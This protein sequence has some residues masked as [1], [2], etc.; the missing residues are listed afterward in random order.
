MITSWIPRGG[1]LPHDVWAARHR[2]L[3]LVLLAH[4]MV[5]PAF[6]VTQGWSLTAAWGFDL[7]P[8]LLGAAACIPRLG[9][10][11]RSSLCA[12]ALLSCSAV[13]VVAWHGTT[14]AHF[15]YFVMV[16]ALALYQ[17]WWTYLIAI[18]FVVLQHGAFGAANTESVFQHAHH[19]WKWAAIHGA[20]VAALAVTSLVSWRESE[21]VREAT[22]ASEERFKRAFDDAPVAIALVSPRGQIVQANRELRERTGHGQPHGLRLWDLLP[23]RDRV[24][25]SQS[26]PPGPD[27][28]E[29]ERR[30]VRADGSTG[31]FLWR[32]SLIR[33]AAGQP[34]HWVFQGVEITA[35]KR[36]AQRLDHQAHHDALTGLPN[37][38]RFD[39]LLEDA[40][41]RG[42]DVAVIFTDLDDFKVIND[43]LGHGTGDQLLLDVA[44]RLARE[45]RAGDVLARFGGDEFVVLLEG[46]D[47]VHDAR[48]TA[49]RLAAALKEPYE[50]GGHQRFLTASF[51][52]AYGAGTGEALLR[53]ADAAMYHAKAQ[54]KARLE[55]FDRSLRTRAVERLELEAGLREA[56]LDGQLELHYQ[57]EIRLGD[58]A[59]YGMEALLRWDHP[60]HGMISPA[61]F[62]PVAEQ[63]GLI[64]PIGAWVLQTA[65]E[66]AA[67]WRAAG[68]TGFVMA[69]NLSPRQLSSPSLARVVDDA[70]RNSGLP[71]HALCL[72]ITESAIM[73]DPEAAQA[74]LQRLKALGVKLAIDDFGVGHSSLSKLKYLLPVDVV[75]IDKSFVDGITEQGDDRAI[76]AAIISLAHELGAVAIAEGVED[77]AQADALRAM[78]C[79]VAQGYH[80]AK[81]LPAYRCL[82]QSE[83]LSA[84][85]PALSPT[86]RTPVPASSKI[87]RNLSA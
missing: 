37:R 22:Q 64:V 38:T 76:I 35:R 85:S 24:E 67:A 50:L 63:S 83:T 47:D 41:G 11:T 12:T 15:H 30:Y 74:V 23:E 66:Q 4:L 10:V 72:E 21:R 62:I 3:L 54:G 58:G 68:H 17:Q 25:L 45:L 55:V 57:S 42:R 44:E 56:I 33:D 49:N 40:L 75:K 13:L 28:P 39:E 80:F 65:C 79:H 7:V 20:F 27:A 18:G 71:A 32:H 29:V 73:E 34:D 1:A 8:A 86:L 48:R 53:D 69:V 82:S 14:E 87:P 36:A 9:R 81:P 70:L 46:L 43:S 16:G 6:A 31:W 5:L 84:A 61:R 60:E 19:P 2:G 51:G 52:I 78:N 59:L 26:W 77:S